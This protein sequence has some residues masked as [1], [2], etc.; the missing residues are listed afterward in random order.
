MVFGSESGRRAVDTMRM[1]YERFTSGIK[2]L[3][4]DKKNLGREVEEIPE[5]ERMVRLKVPLGKDYTAVVVGSTDHGGPGSEYCVGGK[6]NGE[7]QDG[8]FVGAR[9]VNENKRAL[10]AGVVD[11]AGG[12]GDGV[13]IST[14]VNE[15]ISVNLQA[16]KGMEASFDKANEKA[17]EDVPKGR[18]CAV[19]VEIIADEESGKIEMKEGWWGDSTIHVGRD[20]K[21]QP[22]LRSKTQNMAM[23]LHEEEGYH[24]APPDQRSAI[25]SWIG[26][27]PKKNKFS[28]AEFT[29]TELQDN[30]III[31]ASDSLGDVVSDYEI[32][33]ILQESEGAEAIQKALVDLIRQ[34]TTSLSYVIRTSESQNITRTRKPDTKEG[35]NTTVLVVEIKRAKKV[36]D[37]DPYIP[38]VETKRSKDWTESDM[39]EYIRTQL[40]NGDVLPTR[41]DGIIDDIISWVPD[42]KDKIEK[43]EIVDILLDTYFDFRSDSKKS[44]LQKLGYYVRGRLEDAGMNGNK[45]EEV[46][47]SILASTWT[48]EATDDLQRDMA[49]ADIEFFLQTNKEDS[50][51]FP[52]IINDRLSALVKFDKKRGEKTKKLVEELEDEIQSFDGTNR[53]LITAILND[54][55]SGENVPYNMFDSEV[56]NLLGSIRTGVHAPLPPGVLRG[57]G[58]VKEP[59]VTRLSSNVPL[60]DVHADNLERK[61]R[62]RKEEDKEK[63]ELAAVPQQTDLQSLG[64]KKKP[65]WK[66]P[67]TWIATGLAALGISI[68]ASQGANIE[69]KQA[70]QP[71]ND[72]GTGAETDTGTSVSVTSGAR[73]AETDVLGILNAAAERDA[74]PTDT[75]EDIAETNV[76]DAGGKVVE[77]EGGRWVGDVLHLDADVGQD[78]EEPEADV[79]ITVED[80]EKYADSDESEEESETESDGPSAPED[81]E[82]HETRVANLAGRQAEPQPEGEEEESDSAEAEEEAKEDEVLYGKTFSQEAKKGDGFYRLTR[83]I[84]EEIHQKDDALYDKMIDHARQQYDIGGASANDVLTRIITELAK[85]HGTRLTTSGDT[86]YK[87]GVRKDQTMFYIHVGTNG[88]VAMTITG[89]KDFGETRSLR[90][91]KAKRTVALQKNGIDSMDQLSSGDLSAVQPEDAANF[92]TEGFVTLPENVRPGDIVE[93]QGRYYLVTDGVNEEHDA[94]FALPLPKEMTAEDVDKLLKQKSTGSSE[95]TPQEKRA[96]RKA[97]TL[98]EKKK[99]GKAKK[100]KR[101]ANMRAGVHKDKQHRTP[102][103]AFNPIEGPQ[104]AP[105]PGSGAIKKLSLSEAVPRIPVKPL[106]DTQGFARDEVQVTLPPTKTSP[107]KRGISQ[108]GETSTL[109]GETTKP[110]GKKRSRD[111]IKQSNKKASSENTQRNPNSREVR[112]HI[113]FEVAGQKFHRGQK[114]M[115]TSAPRRGEPVTKE[116]IVLGPSK[117]DPPGLVLALYGKG[118]DGK[119]KKIRQFYIAEGTVRSDRLK[120]KT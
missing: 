118:A 2:R 44:S 97:R 119:R 42:E 86:L 35:D 24:S 21:L 26:A 93:H 94:Y 43:K 33:K 111:K 6:H 39:R 4:F 77:V 100:A 8:L 114:V 89:T 117:G 38:I 22:E 113:K 116:H 55:L 69:K 95:L 45:L 98:A 96:Q 11:A 103:I 105:Y 54:I 47:E 23:L 61:E 25:A 20:G 19:A 73:P 88:D 40:V 30:D 65:W 50:Y 112:G 76:E 83:R 79:T 12:H 84:L 48:E 57:E 51:S 115:Y 109:E 29:H 72:P 3:L 15:E 68:A 13:Q 107:R 41:I 31:L 36:A 67:G 120:T 46:T 87:K 17:T 16:N 34:R 10:I 99:R 62:K 106:S 101:A 66:R 74:E 108:I 52:G 59:I 104:A 102:K 81:R 14:V 75:V 60:P 9:E 28:A 71:H 78:L 110:S 64:K 53:T 5:G 56:R 18:A 37:T 32:E 90:E 82:T 27:D 58:M 7:N 70:A 63:S 91:R 49:D 85:P 80:L 92:A 1:E